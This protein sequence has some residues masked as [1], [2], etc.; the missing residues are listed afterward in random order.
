MSFITPIRVAPFISAC[1]AAQGS[2][3]QRLRTCSRRL[4]TFSL[5]REALRDAREPLPGR[6]L[7]RLYIVRPG[8]IEQRR[9]EGIHG[10]R[11]G[12]RAPD[13]RGWRRHRRPRGGAWPR[14][15]GL[16][17]PGA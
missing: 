6:S 4:M 17:G 5:P 14:A 9:T 7:T 2:I 8:G 15:E 10:G 12:G 11:T 3:A 16:L 1:A 13:H